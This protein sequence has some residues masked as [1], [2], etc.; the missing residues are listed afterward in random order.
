MRS[1]ARRAAPPAVGGLGRSR[2]CGVV[3]ED[4]LVELVELGA[5]LD[6]ELLDEH[7]AGVAVGLQRVGLAAAA[8]ER[9]HQLRVQPLAPRVLAGELLELADELGVTP[10]GEVGLD[11]HLHGREVLLFQARDL[12]RRERRR[13]ELGERRPAP[14]LQRL[15]Q[16]RGGV[17]A[18][19]GRQR[20]AAVGDLALEALGVELAG[21]APAGSSPPAW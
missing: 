12:S 18:A 8:V 5:R 1:P 13:G 4:R 19:S 17:L 7:L 9:E 21:H 20:P 16:L 3:G 6:P 2:A 10:G 14:Q 11:A 15:A